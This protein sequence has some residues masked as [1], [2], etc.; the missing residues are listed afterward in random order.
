MALLLD[1]EA[2]KSGFYDSPL[3][4]F[5]LN[6]KII[7]KVHKHVYIREI[8]TKTYLSLKLKFNIIKF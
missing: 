1:L 2:G 3:S 6:N 8:K 4:T 7:A 5:M